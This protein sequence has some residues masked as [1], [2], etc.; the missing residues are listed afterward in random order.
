MPDPILVWDQIGERAYESGLDRGVLY[1]PDGSA[2]PWNGLTSIIE[3]FDRESSPVYYDGAKIADNIILGSFAGTMRAITYPDEFTELEGLGYMRQGMFVGDQRPKAFGLSYRTK[4]GNDVVGQDAGYK[5]HIL[6]NVTAIPLE[7]A[8]ATLSAQASLEEFEWEISA[9]PEEI[10]GFRPTAHFVINSTDIDPWLL[11]DLELMLYG[12]NELENEVDAA[13]IPLS[14][15]AI[16]INDWARITI[17]D[18]EDGTWTATSQRDGLIDIVGDLFTITQANVT[19]LDAD[20][21]VISDTIDVTD[22]T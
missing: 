17:T 6:Y 18:N 19:W 4:I 16:F 7:K 12:S 3:K 1:L 21:Y 22:I 13:L 9:V 2:V 5:I 11:E 15:L 10:P 14:E 20:T 8:H